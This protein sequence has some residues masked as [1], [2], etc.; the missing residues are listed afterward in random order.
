MFW[1]FGGPSLSGITTA[2]KSENCQ[3]EDILSDSSLQQAI[4]NSLRELIDFVTRDEIYNDLF[5]WV[6][7]NKHRDNKLC[8]KLTR[9]ALSIITA[10]S[11]QIQKAISKHNLFVQRIQSFIDQDP[12]DESIND[13]RIAGHFQRITEHF[14]IQTNGNLISQL[15]GLPAFLI[16]NMS[17]LG[18]RELFVSLTTDYT[19]KF[20]LS[21]NDIEELSK[22]TIKENGYFVV[23]AIKSILQQKPEL[24]VQ[25]FQYPIV[26][27]NLLEAAINSRTDQPLATIELCQV[28]CTIVKS[29]TNLEELKILLDEYRSKFINNDT[30]INCST[31]ST[32]LLFKSFNAEFFD[33]LFVKPVNTFL[34]QSI[35]KILQTMPNE[36]RDTIF[37]NFDAPSKLVK[38][39]TENSVNG[40]F[41]EL[42][43]I[44]KET[45]N[46]PTP[47]IP[48]IQNENG[49]S[50]SNEATNEPANQISNEA[51]GSTG[52]ETDNSNTNE[53]GN[54]ATNTESKS[55]LSEQPKLTI[56]LPEGWNELS[57]IIEKAIQRQ[58]V[59]YGGPM[60]R[61][62][63][64]YSSDSDNELVPES[65]SSDEFVDEDEED[66]ED[67]EISEEEEEEEA[68]DKSSSDDEG[69]EEEEEGNQQEEAPH[70]N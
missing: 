65:S 35:I 2:L 39:F 60:P 7:T 54:P 63:N 41:Y 4:R 15:K 38:N 37:K 58:K 8:Q 53:S 43:Q 69:K 70:D 11:Q 1:N 33:H 28:L 30:K 61:N 18:L 55:E 12:N 47:D 66:S 3:L 23:T 24:I 29:C 59:G 68:Q 34:N 56:Q 45:Y 27:K 26:V 5:D 20:G 62:S 49:G 21:N 40:Q 42:Y 48:Q 14:A 19:E 6:L 10:N 13:A 31:A 50:T 67:P 46:L 9:N 17:I 16:H 64:T 44:I 32:I 51:S 36:Q 25:Y 22:E 57:I 52:N